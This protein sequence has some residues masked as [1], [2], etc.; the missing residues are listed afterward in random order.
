MVVSRAVCFDKN[1]AYPEFCAGLLNVPFYTSHK[2]VILRLKCQLIQFGMG[3]S[4]P[5]LPWEHAKW[6]E[7]RKNLGGMVGTGEQKGQSMGG[8]ELGLRVA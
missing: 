5:S 1:S 7:V 8:G 3:G 2:M 6:P 4:A